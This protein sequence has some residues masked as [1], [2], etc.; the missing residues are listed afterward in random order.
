MVRYSLIL[1]DVRD[2]VLNSRHM[3]LA[4]LAQN[5]LKACSAMI[6]YSMVL[7]DVRD[8]ILNSR[9]YV[10]MTCTK[11]T[12]SALCY[13]ATFLEFITSSQTSV[14]HPTIVQYHTIIIVQY[15]T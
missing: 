6:R 2:D 3:P 15:H 4:S 8:D 14:L 10:R 13:G 7:T 9:H 12:E 11:L 1:T 5:S